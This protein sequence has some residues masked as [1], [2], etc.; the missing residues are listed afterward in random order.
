[1]EG[2]IA[3]DTYTQGSWFASQEDCLSMESDV[4]AAYNVTQKY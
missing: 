4:P 2:G 3:A 1:M